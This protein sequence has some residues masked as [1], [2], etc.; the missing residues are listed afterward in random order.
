MPDPTPYELVD[1]VDEN[2]DVLRQT[3]KDA[4]FKNLPRHVAVIPDGNRRWARGR[5]L[6]A[7]QGHREGR[8][9]FREI[10]EAVWRLGIPYFTFWAASE[11]NLSKRSRTEVKLLALLMRQELRRVLA[12]KEFITKELRIRVIGRWYDI[13]K[14]K[15]LKGLA[16]QLE[17]ASRSFTRHHLTILFGYNGDREMIEAIEKIQK[18]SR[19]PVDAALI[20]N[21]LWT[22]DLPPV[23][24]VIRTGGEPHWSAGFMMWHTQNAQ[25]YFTDT[26]WPDFVENELTKALADYGRRPRRFGA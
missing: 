12:Q 2:D 22:R 23:D 5:G 13:L 15:T 17:G 6:L 20:R 26:L 3:T 4:A 11:D 24:L 18:E 21:A 7:L 16:E 9:R 14:D 8:L 25:L 10:R 19:Q 1:V